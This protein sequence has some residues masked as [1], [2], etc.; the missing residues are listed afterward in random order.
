[1]T[2]SDIPRLVEKYAL[3]EGIESSYDGWAGRGDS[4][5]DD[6]SARINYSL[7]RHYKP[8]VVVEF[9]SRTGRCTPSARPAARTSCCT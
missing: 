5:Y 2:N 3:G 8:K 6:D 1:M 4:Q 7:V 9:G